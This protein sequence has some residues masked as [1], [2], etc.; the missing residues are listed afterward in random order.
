[1]DDKTYRIL[2][3]VAIA[4]GLFFVAWTM[5]DGFFPDEPES[6]GDAPYHAANK[7]FA[8][9]N[10]QR[11][12]QEYQQ[13]ALA[14]PA[15]EFARRGKALT[16]M[17]LE[18]YPEAL[19]LFNKILAGEVTEPAFLYANRGILL[20]RMG[21]YEEALADYEKSLT[22]NAEVAEGPNWL[23]RFLRL[24]P[25]KPPSVADRA[26]YLQQELAKPLEQRLLRKPEE[27]AKQRSYQQ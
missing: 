11:A 10:Y 6:P 20:D 24:Q 21:R 27:D 2:V 7:F 4:M 3:S 18:R 14:D 23:D 8:D 9:G 19:D 17:Q 1:M 13:A 15:H 22:L 12:L 25:Q 5:Y 26:A 16:L